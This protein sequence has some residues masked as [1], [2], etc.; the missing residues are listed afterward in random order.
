MDTQALQEAG[1]SWPKVYTDLPGSLGGRRL[2]SVDLFDQLSFALR[3]PSF[4]FWFLHH[5][6]ALRSCGD[7]TMC[8]DLLG[9]YSDK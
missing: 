4:D 9:H 8:S 6:D 3:S 1:K 5:G 7:Y 2:S